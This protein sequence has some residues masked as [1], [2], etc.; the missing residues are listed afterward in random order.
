MEV[1]D[2]NKESEKVSEV[3][4]FR[5]KIKGDGEVHLEISFRFDVI[6]L[7]YSILLY[8]FLCAKFH[9]F[10]YVLNCVRMV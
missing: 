10:F 5:G 4:G 3:V 6:I 7:T 2:S 9:K 1:G 8:T